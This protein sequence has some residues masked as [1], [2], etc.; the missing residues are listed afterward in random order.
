MPRIQALRMLSPKRNLE[1]PFARLVAPTACSTG[2]SALVAFALLAS[3]IEAP[4][5][6]PLVLGGF[7]SG[8]E[9]GCGGAF[10]KLIVA[11]ASLLGELC[12]FLIAK[13][14]QR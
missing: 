12:W 1:A 4:G 5:S 3:T 13:M 2:R 8:S 7:R 10:H 14:E 6:R 11:G 9:P